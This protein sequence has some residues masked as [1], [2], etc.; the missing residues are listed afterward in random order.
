MLKLVTKDVKNIDRLI[1]FK[2]MLPA[3]LKIRVEEVAFLNR[4]SLSQEIVAALEEKVS[5]SRCKGR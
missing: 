3:D 1:Q 5:N 4:R 2:L